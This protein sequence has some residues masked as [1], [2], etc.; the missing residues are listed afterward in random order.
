VQ[1]EIFNLDYKSEVLK[2]E[3]IDL[4]GQAFFRITFPGKEQT[5]TILRATHFNGNKF[6][7]SMPE[8]KQK[9]AEEIGILIEQYYRAKN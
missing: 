1:S 2:A 4:S 9:L 7:T 6:W 5:L 3:R 8:G